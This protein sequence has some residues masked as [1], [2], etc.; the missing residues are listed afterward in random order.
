[1][2]ANRRFFLKAVG[3]LDK[4]FQDRR[5]KDDF[6]C[7]RVADALIELFK[8]RPPHM[9]SIYEFSEAVGSALFFQDQ[10]AGFCGVEEISES[11][12]GAEPYQVAFLA[13]WSIGFDAGR[14]HAG[15]EHDESVA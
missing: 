5:L 13:G 2:T 4:Y 14:K 9:R 7:D 6:S 3:M 1:M 11:C 15:D 12:K 8:S 10:G